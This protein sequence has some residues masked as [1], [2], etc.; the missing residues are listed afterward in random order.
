MALLAAR[1]LSK[2]FGSRLILDG[3]DFDVEPGVRMGVIGPNGGGKS[4]LLRI[5]AAE[6]IADAGELTARRGLVVAY[7][8]QQ[9][10]G[11]DRDAL[12]TLRAARPDLDELEADLERVEAQLSGLGGDL[13]RMT[14]ALRR[15]EELVERWTAA[16]GPGF[17]GRARA[18]L[19]D[20]GLGD[21]DLGKPTRVLSGG[22]RKLVGLAAC[23]LR[24]PDVLLLD[25]PEAHLDV[26]ARERI[27]R[28]MRS[29]DGSVVAVSHDRYLLD[30]TVSEIA[31]L[32]GG[33]VRVWPGN[34]SAYTVARE[35]ELQRQQ[36][37]YVTQQ[38]EIARLEEAIRRFKD[39]ASRVADERHIK[40]ARNK[41]RQIDRMEKIDRPVLERRKIA[42]ELRPH[43]RGGER[44]VELAGAGVE[45]AGRTILD[46]VDLTVL[47]GERVGVVGDNGAG[48]SVL[49]RMLAGEL[50][51]SEGER[52]AGPSIRFGR[53]EQD[54]RPDDPQATPLQL[55]RRA[56]PMSEGEAVSR[57]MKFLFGYEQVRRPLHTLSGGEWTRLQLLLLMLAG[58]NCLLLD[59][60]T[61]HLDIES[62]EMLES[63]LEGFEGTAIFVSHDRY[64]LDR[65]A[66]RILEVGNGAVRSYE[67]GWSTWRERQVVG[68]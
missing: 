65:I 45:L 11:D 6:E 15:Q 12:H 47:R 48:K 66:D 27:E 4:T 39:W 35:L 21:E 62:V 17:D 53:L 43:A 14:R 3:L 26:E 10:E 19:V 16:G 54:R 2:S 52:K 29:F 40:Q 33:R 34:Y 64:F 61:N 24:D 37:A 8:P 51:P 49:L 67:G 57:L 44:V 28:L 42:L 23:L 59:E 63:A 56:A 41:Q 31:E 38:K 50:E 1:G 30:E 68:V 7:L 5:L 25:E 36:Q 9:L 20:V 46:G 13:E 60:P 22:Q 55:V 18:L 32:A 58:A